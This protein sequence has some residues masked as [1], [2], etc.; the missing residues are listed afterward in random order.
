MPDSAIMI[1][2]INRF[3]DDYDLTQLRADLVMIDDDNKTAPENIPE[4]NSNNSTDI[5][6]DWKCPSVS[7]YRKKTSA[8]KYRAQHD[9]RSHPRYSRSF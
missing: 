9:K 4:N 7:C 3:I 6:T 8:C 2:N 5:F 1:L